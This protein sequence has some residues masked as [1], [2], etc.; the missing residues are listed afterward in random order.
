MKFKALLSGAAMV[1]VAAFALGGKETPGQTVDSGS[2]GVFLGG[3]RVATETFSIEQQATGSV[4]TSEFKMENGGDQARQSSELQLS[5]TG[6]LRRYDWKEITPGKA[7]ATVTP[8]DTFLMQRSIRN[9][10]EKAEEQPYILPLA[11]SILDDY[12]FVHREI[13]AWRYLKFGCRENHG[14]LECPKGQKVQLGVLVPHSRTSMLVSM[15]FVGR[16]KVPVRGEERELNRLT[17]KGDSGEWALWLD[18][19][20][21][22]V[23]IL[24]P[25]DNTEVVRD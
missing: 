23:R 2:F 7:Q 8:N 11:T 13:L 14:R 10:G 15:E 6:D 19:Q 5:L 25:E 9:P 3:R 4:V 18:D 1:T 16:E 17:L 24:V 12:F 20:Y 22:L 21:K